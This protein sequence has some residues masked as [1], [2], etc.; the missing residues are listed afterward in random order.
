MIFQKIN[1]NKLRVGFHSLLFFSI[2]FFGLLFGIL[3]GLKAQLFIYFL[4]CCLIALITIKTNYIQADASLVSALMFLT[5]GYAILGT[6]WLINYYFEKK[7]KDEALLI[8]AENQKY[9]DQK[10][11]IEEKEKILSDYFAGLELEKLQGLLQKIQLNIENLNDLAFIEINSMYYDFTLYSYFMT[12][13]LKPI[14]NFWSYIYMENFV[15]FF[16]FMFIVT[17]FILITYVYSVFFNLLTIKTEYNIFLK[18]RRDQYLYKITVGK[19]ELDYYLFKIYN[20]THCYIKCNNKTLKHEFH[21]LDL[22][23]Y[24]RLLDSDYG[25][26]WKYRAQDEFSF[27]LTTNNFASTETEIFR[28]L[29]YL[30]GK[31]FTISKPE[32][33]F[34]ET[35]DAHAIFCNDW[36]YKP[37]IF[38]IL[39]CFI[40]FKKYYIWYILPQYLFNKDAK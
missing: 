40:P 13:L 18:N 2:I 31:E 21:D 27:L 28:V 1:K 15:F 38:K 23:V 35:S 25:D 14:E 29:K 33:V 20:Q 22:R 17:L 12:F 34:I 4:I 24:S 39:F 16:S 32:R 36:Q 9:L 30:F 3:L 10:T 19:I 26:V 5:L 11:S 8:A 37:W 6:G 7:A